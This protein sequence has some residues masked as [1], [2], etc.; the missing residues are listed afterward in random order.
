MAIFLPIIVSVIAT[1]ALV[2][3]RGILTKPRHDRNS[4]PRRLTGVAGAAYTSA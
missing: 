3:M 4:V 1:V 2:L